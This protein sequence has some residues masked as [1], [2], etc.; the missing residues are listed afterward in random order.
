MPLAFSLEFNLCLGNVS[1][2]QKNV[3]G[4]TTQEQA[5][6][7]PEE[8]VKG[9]ILNHSSSACGYVCNAGG[10][11]FHGDEFISRAMTAVNEWQAALTE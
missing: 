5:L 11:I 3:S 10:H 1:S 8:F 6:L 2:F 7:S 4:G 9:K